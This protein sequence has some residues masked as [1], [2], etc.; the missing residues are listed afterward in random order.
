MNQAYIKGGADCGS[1]SSVPIGELA[2]LFWALFTRLLNLLWLWLI[3]FFA[4]NIVVGAE[5]SVAAQN[6]TVIVLAYMLLDV[7]LCLLK[8]LKEWLCNLE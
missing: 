3:A 1:C 6:A 7:L 8:S 5:Y 2:T 4:T